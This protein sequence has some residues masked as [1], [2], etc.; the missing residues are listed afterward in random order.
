MSNIVRILVALIIA[1]TTSVSHGLADS[2]VSDAGGASQLLTLESADGEAADSI[3]HRC[4][5]PTGSLANA[6]VPCPF[7]TAVQTGSLSL[8][9]RLGKQDFAGHSIAVDIGRSNNPDH[10]PPKPLS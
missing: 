3:S 2:V 5:S 10:G 7:E 6:R 9:V 4:A 1:L 8:A